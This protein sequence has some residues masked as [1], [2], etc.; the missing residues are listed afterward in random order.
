MNTQI[1]IQYQPDDLAD[2]S[3]DAYDAAL[4]AALLSR[5]PNAEITIERSGQRCWGDD[6][7]TEIS[8]VELANIQNDVFA[9]ICR[10]AA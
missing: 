3:P 4:K 8:R 6:N 7:G 2:I 5:W 10:G 9:A 1:G